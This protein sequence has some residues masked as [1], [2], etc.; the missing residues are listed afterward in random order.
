MLPGSE[1][2][3]KRPECRGNWNLR[4]LVRTVM[5][6]LLL[7][8]ELIRIY[9]ETTKQEQNKKRERR[10]AYPSVA[11]LEDKIDDWE[12]VHDGALSSCHVAPVPCS[13]ELSHGRP[14][15]PREIT[16]P[17]HSLRFLPLGRVGSG[18]IWFLIESSFFP[19]FNTDPIT[20]YILL[21]GPYKACD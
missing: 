15:P 1:P 17:R 18:R 10:A 12:S 20:D 14:Q 4:N 13:S 19:G 21:I 16:R 8:M 9:G 6:I 11:N 7:P 5:Q 2:A 3:L